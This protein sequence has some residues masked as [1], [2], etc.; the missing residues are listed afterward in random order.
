MVQSELILLGYWSDGAQ[1]S[2]WPDV[3]LFVDPSCAEYERDVVEEY[4]SRGVIV[5]ACMGK[6]RCRFCGEENGS[7]ELRDGVYIWPEGLAHYVRDH[8]VRLPEEFVRHVLARIDSLAERG[9]SDS[10]WKSKR[11]SPS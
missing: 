5:W 6:S 8:H 4:L 9:R 7:L 10:W 3:A 1:D 11:A 2:D